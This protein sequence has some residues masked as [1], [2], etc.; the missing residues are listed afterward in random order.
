MSFWSF[1]H[2]GTKDDFKLHGKML[3]NQ[4][5]SLFKS[6]RELFLVLLEQA[7]SLGLDLKNY[8]P[9]TKGL[10]QLED[11]IFKAKIEKIRAH[12]QV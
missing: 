2:R 11:D 12:E 4:E 3:E 1:W 10:I 7:S 5:Y 6:Q 9:D 8:E